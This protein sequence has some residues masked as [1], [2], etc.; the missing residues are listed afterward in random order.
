MGKDRYLKWKDGKIDLFHLLKSCGHLLVPT[1][2]AR[3]HGREKGYVYFQE[4]IPDNAFDIRIIVC[5]KRA[6]G[7]KRLERFPGIGKRTYF[8]C[9]GRN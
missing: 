8:V 3:L 6:F 2:Y 7:I 5:G 1:E 9:T 4:F